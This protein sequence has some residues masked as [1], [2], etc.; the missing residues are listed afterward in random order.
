MVSGSIRLD[1]RSKVLIKMF[2]SR[3]FYHGMA[4]VSF[5]GLIFNALATSK[6]T[7]VAPLGEVPQ[8]KKSGFESQ[9]WVQILVLL[10]VNYATLLKSVI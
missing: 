1:L 7:F 8:F 9:V 2:W 10:L 6:G 5:F 4:G 3:V